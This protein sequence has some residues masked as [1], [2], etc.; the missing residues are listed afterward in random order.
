MRR[1]IVILLLFFLYANGIKGSIADGIDLYSVYNGLPSS[2]IQCL[3]LDKKGFIWIGTSDGLSKFDG[4]TFHNYFAS[5]NALTSL[6][7]DNIFDIVEDKRNNLVFLTE[8][9]I[10]FFDKEKHI[11]IAKC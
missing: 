7:N 2:N 1:L 11:F 3:H 6:Q 8:N 4:Y 5:D 9:G 10:E